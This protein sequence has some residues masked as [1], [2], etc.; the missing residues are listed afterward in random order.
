M[1][2]RSTVRMEARFYQGTNPAPSDPEVFTSFTIPDY[3][4]SEFYK[5]ASMIFATS[6]NLTVVDHTGNT[7]VKQ[8]MVYVVDTTPVVEKARGEKP[9]L[10][11]KKIFLN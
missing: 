8:I 4:E 2:Q 7:Y 9:D 10:S 1:Q 3:Q 5:P 11:V 6:E